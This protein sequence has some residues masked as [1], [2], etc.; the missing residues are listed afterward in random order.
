M[1]AGY[2]EEEESTPFWQSAWD[3]V[4]TSVSLAAANVVS[5]VFRE[6]GPKEEFIRCLTEI[7][8]FFDDFLQQPDKIADEL[9][10]RTIDEHPELVALKLRLYAEAPSWTSSRSYVDQGE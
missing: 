3:T 2:S 7:A 1:G 6:K 5:T 4:H 9:Q 8:A 10:V